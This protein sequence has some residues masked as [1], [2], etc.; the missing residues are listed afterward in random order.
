VGCT[1]RG[2]EGV[3]SG[4]VADQR[5]FQ[6]VIIPECSACGSFTQSE[7]ISKVKIIAVLVDSFQSREGNLESERGHTHWHTTE[8]IWVTDVVCRSGKERKFTSESGS[9]GR[10][11]D[12]LKKSKCLD[13]LGQFSIVVE[14]C[15]LLLGA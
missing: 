6:K 15:G 12:R 8:S 13:F 9:Q 10:L 11:I 14:R 2:F 5:G 7:G 1:W 3:A 4:E